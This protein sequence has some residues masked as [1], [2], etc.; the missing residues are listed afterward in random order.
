MPDPK[1]RSCCPVS[2]TLDLIGD[3]WTLLI[4]RDLLLGRT[5]YKEFAASPEQIA[6][7]ILADRLRRLTDQ[8]IIEQ[9]ASTERAGR[10]T[11]RLT[12]KGKALKPVLQSITRWGLNHLEGTEVRLKP[13]AR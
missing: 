4:V 2:C 12:K 5:Q 10:S 7:N 13:P 8:G 3:K 1:R 6:T 9:V 11:Y